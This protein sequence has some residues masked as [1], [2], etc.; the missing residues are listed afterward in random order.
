MK[1]L[2]SRAAPI[3]VAIIAIAVSVCAYQWGRR[4]ARGVTATDG[5]AFAGPK[6]PMFQIVGDSM[7]PTLTD[8]QVYQIS[9]VR[10]E[11]WIGDVV[12]IE[13]DGKRHVKRIAALGGNRVDLVD[14][15]LTIDGRRLEDVIATRADSGQGRDA[16]LPPALVAVESQPDHWNRSDA[17]AN[18]LVYGYR[19]PYQAG[20]ITA[21]MDDYPTN[22]SVRR[23]L[24]PVDRLVIQIRPRAGGTAPKSNPIVAV[25]FFDPSHAI[26]ATQARSGQA[27]YR[28]AR[29]EVAGASADREQL[30]AALDAAHPVAVQLNQHQADRYTLHVYR[31][32]EYRDDRPS[33]TVSYPITLAA[34]DVFV[35][36]DNVPVSVDSRTVG[37]LKQSAVVGKVVRPAE[38][39]Q[40]R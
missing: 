38:L 5:P 36:G 24:N 17:A 21:V 34:D 10:E 40:G 27:R 39:A 9:D 32:I 28:D 35:V 11:L 8:G 22:H 30:V 6:V 2:V 4:S 26:V 33:G 25:T 15:R 23:I 20:R 29:P 19:N 7:A 14:G 13:W 3:V 12:A 37:P 18:W 31:E 1:S 16:F